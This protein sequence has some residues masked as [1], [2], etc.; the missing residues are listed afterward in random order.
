MSEAQTTDADVRAWSLV[1]GLGRVGFGIAM[2]T[3]PEWALRALGFK[4]VS[5]ATVAVTR[6]AGGRDLVLGLVTMAALDDRDRLRGATLANTLA[7]TSDTLAFAIALGTDERAA[8]SRGL[9]A[10]LPAALAGAW[11]AWRLS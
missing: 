10:A 11:T 9:A 4:E 2:L 6:L 8:G 7:D 1:S 3:A 5:P